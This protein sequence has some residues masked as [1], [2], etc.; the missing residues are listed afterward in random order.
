M[1]DYTSHQVAF[2]FAGAHLRDNSI[3]GSASD[4]APMLQA[5]AKAHWDELMAEAKKAPVATTE[6]TKTG[7]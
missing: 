4:L 2:D 3:R 5:Y 1:K 7:A 6:T